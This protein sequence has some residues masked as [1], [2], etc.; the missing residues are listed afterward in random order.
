MLVHPGSVSDRAHQRLAGPGK[1]R[2]YSL[3]T[4]WAIPA[5]RIAPRTLSFHRS[6]VTSPTPARSAGA[7]L[8]ALIAPPTHPRPSSAE[9]GCIDRILPIPLRCLLRGHDRLIE[10]GHRQPGPVTLEHLLHDESSQEFRG[11]SSAF[12][13]Y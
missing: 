8:E 10:G 5:I 7:L 1:D 2:T 13:V 12:S 4:K 11:P 6:R 3:G 9:G